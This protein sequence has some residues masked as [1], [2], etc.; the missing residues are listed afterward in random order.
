MYARTLLLLAGAVGLAA[1]ASAQTAPVD[2]TLFHALEW[3]MIGPLRGGR[4][5][6]VAGH[7]DQPYVYFMG[8]TG[9]GV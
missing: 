6:A 2:S 8:T 5:T 7:A 1:P 3:R 4:V 9:G